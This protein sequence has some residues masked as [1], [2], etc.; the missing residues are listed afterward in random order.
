MSGWPGGQG[1]K[2]PGCP[3]FGPNEGPVPGLP[4]PPLQ[5]TLIPRLPWFS[6][7]DFLPS[8]ATFQS[9]VESS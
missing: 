4:A 2:A 9:C 8:P 1:S 5:D 6:C 3:S 7:L